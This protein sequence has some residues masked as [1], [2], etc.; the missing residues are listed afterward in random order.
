MAHVRQSRPDS[1][2]G[3]QVRVLS[4]RTD[5]SGTQREDTLGSGLEHGCQPSIILIIHPVTSVS[6]C[7]SQASQAPNEADPEAKHRSCTPC[8]PTFL[9]VMEAG[10]CSEWEVSRRAA[11][12]TPRTWKRRYDPALTAGGSNLRCP[13]IQ[14]FP[15]LNKLLGLGFGVPCRLKR[16][17]GTRLNWSWIRFFD[18]HQNRTRHLGYRMSEADSPRSLR[19]L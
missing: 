5:E 14:A 6:S 8:T 17:Q 2:L 11:F 9:L 7:S 18:V 12:F 10:I 4:A 16:L 19:R 15:Y 13:T 3:S 1:G